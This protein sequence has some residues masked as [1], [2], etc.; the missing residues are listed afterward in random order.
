MEVRDFRA[1]AAGAGG[2]L[3]AG[4]RSGLVLAKEGVSKMLSPLDFLPLWAK[5]LAAKLAASAAILFVAFGWLKLHDS[6]VKSRVIEASK[7]EARKDVEISKGAYSA[8][9]DSTSGVRSKYRRD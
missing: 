9:L 6:K 5:K 2:V 8:S 3:I 4:A 1:S 7:T